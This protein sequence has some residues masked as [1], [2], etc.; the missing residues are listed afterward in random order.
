MNRDKRVIKPNKR[1]IEQDEEVVVK[2]KPKKQK[3]AV[4]KK[5]KK[6]AQPPQQDKLD[7]DIGT[8][9]VIDPKQI[10]DFS[11]NENPYWINHFYI[12]NDSI[13]EEYGALT[14][15]YVD[16]FDKLPFEFLN[17][18]AQLEVKPQYKKE[19]VQQISFKKL[20][21]G[22]Y[23]IKSSKSDKTNISNTVSFF[24]KHLPSFKKYEK[25]DDI[26]WVAKENRK[27]FN[28]ILEYSLI[29]NSA[30]TTIKGKINALCRILRLS[31]KT[32]NYY[33]YQKYAHLVSIL[34][35][36]QSNTDSKNLLTELELKKFLPYDV[37]LQKEKDMFNEFNSMTE[38]E[39]VSQK[40]YNLNQNILLLGFYTLI[41]PLRDEPKTLEYT[42]TD[43]KDKDY[44][45]IK[46]DGGVMLLLNLEKKKHD[47]EDVDLT[48]RSPLLAEILIQS[49]N[50]YPRIPLFAVKKGDTY[51]KKQKSTL[52]QNLVKLFSKDYPSKNVGSSSIRSSYY[53]WV[54]TLAIEQGVPLSYEAKED[55]A[56]KMRTSVEQLDKSY[57][58]IYKLTN[59][60]NQQQQPIIEQQQQQQSIIPK[61]NSY[62]KKLEKNKE[63]IQKNKEKIY[64]Q[65][66]E[67]KASIPKEDATRIR[68]LRML[69]NDNEYKNH[70]RKST[71]EKYNFRL[72]E[73][74]KYY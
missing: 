64:K 65:Q 25:D 29:N 54:N 21:E 1:Y 2:P 62:Y 73:N 49:Y 41:A 63:Y 24:R 10:R 69:N 53:S 5:P 70:I 55:L 45:Y 3:K 58:K 17:G 8:D 68:L 35:Q 6:V 57:L 7:E 15:K 44:V 19:I 39:K 22:F 52:S 50:L 71:I 34:G 12:P 74:N 20:K 59:P 16:F 42:F 26:T 61:T 23:E 4:P 11:N 43:K 51:Q 32:K 37:I 47:P 14:D 27:L 72:D 9:E 48:K 30:I 67:Y 66:K 56:D 13:N 40:G 36:T 31:F 33:V 38:Q 60:V 28:E 18:I 46:K